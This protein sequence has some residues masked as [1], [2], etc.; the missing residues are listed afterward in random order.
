MRRL[1]H[2]IPALRKFVKNILPFWFVVNRRRRDV[3]SSFANEE[4]ML[5]K[6]SHD[7]G[8]FDVAKYDPNDLWIVD[9]GASNGFTQS[10]SRR[11]AYFFNWNSC[12]VECD[13]CKFSELALLYS[14]H[15]CASLVKCKVTPTNI[16][17]ILHASNVPFRFSILN[18]DIDSWDLDVINSLLLAG[19]RPSI[20]SMEINENIP[21]GVFFSVK[22]RCDHSWNYD[23]FFG[24]SLTAASQVVRPF[25]YSLVSVEWNNAFFVANDCSSSSVDLS[26]SYALSTGYSK[27]SDRLQLFP[28]NADV[29]HWHTLPP[30]EAVRVI[31]SHFSNYSDDLYDL[32][33]VDF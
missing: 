1:L 6:L 27:R 20:I 22:Y 24:C 13:S 18:L 16:R 7:I 29:D 9:I 25:G 3:D 5:L 19:F 21:A 26:D 31:K 8:L 15:S 33:S 12:L 4:S 28:W 2:F 14:N 23:K 11:F 32:R 10:S 17:H 30:A